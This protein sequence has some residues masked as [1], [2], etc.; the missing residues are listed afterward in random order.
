MR[1]CFLLLLVIHCLPTEITETTENNSNN[2]LSALEK[3]IEE[4]AFR[5]KTSNAHCNQKNFFRTDPVILIFRKNVLDRSVTET[6]STIGTL[7]L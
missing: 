3:K 2:Y 1:L 4:E 5:R 7:T 6:R